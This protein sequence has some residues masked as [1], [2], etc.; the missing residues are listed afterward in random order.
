VIAVADAAD[1]DVHA[2]S[3]QC[4]SDVLLVESFD[5]FSSHQ[6]LLMEQSTMQAFVYHQGYS[7]ALLR[8]PSVHW[9]SQQITDVMIA[10]LQ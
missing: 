7:P 10:D 1:D 6:L 9:H 2:D 8:L 3:L 4:S 5:S